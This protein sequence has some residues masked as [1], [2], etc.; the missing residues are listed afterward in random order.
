MEYVAISDP[1]QRYGRLTLLEPLRGGKWK[2]RCDCG[3]VVTPV[4]ASVRRG[5][6][7]SCGCFRREFSAKKAT[8]HGQTG[9]KTYQ[10][11]QA[12][13]R[14]CLNPNVAEFPLYGGRGIQVCERWRSFDNFLADLGEIPA[15]LS[16]DRINPNGNYEPSNCR[17]VDQ[18]VQQNNRRNTH[19]VIFEGV[20]CTLS[21]VMEKLG[22]S[23]S[24]ARRRFG[25]PA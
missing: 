25:I 21:E 12:M 15:G 7:K 3:E 17:L 13:K 2:M 4:G 24:T 1:V 20:E 9:S 10:T 8:T 16:I 6:T 14:R 18:T 11:W 23:R 5:L 19:R 22:I